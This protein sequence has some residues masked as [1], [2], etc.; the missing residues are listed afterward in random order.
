MFQF[1]LFADH[2]VYSS[3]P[4]T[5]HTARVIREFAPQI[6]GEFLIYVAG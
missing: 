1:W 4:H 6:E 2:G 5:L 3:V